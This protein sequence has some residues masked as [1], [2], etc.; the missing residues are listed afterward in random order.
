MNG[1]ANNH[2]EDGRSPKP[3]DDENDDEDF[4]SFVP[5]DNGGNNRG[6]DEEETTT[7]YSNNDN[8]GEKTNGKRR[9]NNN[10][11]V[12]K[13]GLPP[14]MDSYVDHFRVNPMIALHNE[15]VSFCKLMEPRKEEMK[16]REDL[17][18]KFTKLAK[19]TFRNCKVDLFGSQA[20][21]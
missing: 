1:T 3:I 20:T 17:L 11:I 15:I 7:G 14:W 19:S 18:Q 16:I 2:E 5:I 9:N 12:N 21:G 6:D 10:N 13:S 4:I 8:T